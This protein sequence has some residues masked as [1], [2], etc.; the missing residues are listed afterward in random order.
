MKAALRRLSSRLFLAAVLCAV[1]AAAGAWDLAPTEGSAAAQ[2]A[3]G[4]PKLDSALEKVAGLSASSLRAQARRAM[5]L[6]T[7]Q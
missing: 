6:F 5:P 4:H 3:K 2:P 1:L 7:S